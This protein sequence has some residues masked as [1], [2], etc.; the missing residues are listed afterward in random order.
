MLEQVRNGEINLLSV[1]IPLY[2]VIVAVICL[3][4]A[5]K[6]NKNRSI[7]LLLGLIP[8]INIY[9][10]IYYLICKADTVDAEKI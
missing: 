7:A 1:I 9:F 5:F 10:L 6:K 8:G 2:M 4:L 3:K